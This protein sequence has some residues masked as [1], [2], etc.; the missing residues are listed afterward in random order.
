MIRDWRILAAARLLAK[1]SQKD[2]ADKADVAIGAVQQLESGTGNPRLSTLV[3]ITDVLEQHGVRILE[4]DDRIQTGVVLLKSA[5]QQNL[6]KHEK[7]PGA[8]NDD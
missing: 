5:G 8:S 2:L 7:A 1:L 3:A 4:A 6:P